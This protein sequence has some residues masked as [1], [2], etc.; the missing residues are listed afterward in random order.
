MAI[1]LPLLIALPLLIRSKRL[2]A[3]LL[4]ERIPRTPA[5]KILRRQLKPLAAARR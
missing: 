3:V 4:T 1:F 2:A 5:G